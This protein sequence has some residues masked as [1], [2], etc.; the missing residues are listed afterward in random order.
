MN[1]N[2]LSKQ[3]VICE[4][5]RP[6]LK[7]QNAGLKFL[8]LEE[9]LRIL[10]PRRE[11]ETVVTSSGTFLLPHFGHCDYLEK[12]ASHGGL[13]VVCVNTDDSI[14]RLGRSPNFVPIHGRI[15]FVAAQSSVHYV[16]L[17]DELTP[18]EILSYLR[19][20]V[21]TKGADWSDRELPERAVVESY[22]GRIVIIPITYNFS[23]SILAG[24]IRGTI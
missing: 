5:V 13:H 17:F 19:P 6:Q 16:T 9:I 18:E 24:N 8:P 20:N 1:D 22:G 12:A 10:D 11:N 4:A 21:H 2:Y 3:R 7:T 15:V 14:R 23:S